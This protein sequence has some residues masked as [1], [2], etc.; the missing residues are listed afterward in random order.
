MTDTAQA[1][2]STRSV[3][4]ESGAEQTIGDRIQVHATRP[5]ALRIGER[6]NWQSAFDFADEAVEHPMPSTG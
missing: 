3:R 5:C 2:V 4:D 1:G 6:H